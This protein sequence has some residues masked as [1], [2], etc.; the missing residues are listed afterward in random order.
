MF[1]S[2]ILIMNKMKKV[3]YISILSLLAV[4]TSCQKEVIKPNLGNEN[5]EKGSARELGV[6]LNSSN[7]DDIESVF[8]PRSQGGSG[9]RVNSNVADRP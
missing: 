6:G 5:I 1:V 8:D 9:G 3:V 2:C 4:F 7:D